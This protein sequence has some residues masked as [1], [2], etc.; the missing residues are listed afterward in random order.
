MDASVDSPNFSR[1]LPCT[2]KL[3]ERRQRSQSQVRQFSD[4]SGFRDMTFESFD[5]TIR[6][7]Q[8]AFE[9]ALAFARHPHRWLVLVG[10]YGCGKTH[11][12][13]AIANYA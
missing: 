10:P 13:A 2:C 11:L 7:A 5:P 1:L 12:A 3:E 8:E 4:M 6:G 9:S